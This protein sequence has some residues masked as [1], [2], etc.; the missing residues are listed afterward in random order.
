MWKANNTTEQLAD[1]W[2]DQREIQNL[3]GHYVSRLLLKQEG[4]VFDEFWSQFEED[5]CIGLNDGWY[6]GRDA[7][8]DYYKA[9]VENTAVRSALIQKLFP[10]YLGHL[11]KDEVHGV[12]DLQVDALCSPIIE[13]SGYGTTA[14]GLWFFTGAHNAILPN[15]PYTFL[16]NGYYAVDFVKEGVEWK[17]WHLQRICETTAPDGTNWAEQWELPPAMDDFKELENL[18]MPP[19][20]QEKVNRQVYYAGRPAQE[21]VRIPEPFYDFK[22]TFS[23]GLGQ[24][25]MSAYRG[26]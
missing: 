16:I 5:V 6:V 19:Y 7:V 15:G 10:D 23:Y 18:K 3:M 9:L 22:D 4:T 20:T 25:V 2:M 24:R 12:G 1:A 26:H 21:K 13:V 8:G 14:K 17:I 11:S